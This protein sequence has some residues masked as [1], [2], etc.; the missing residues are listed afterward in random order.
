MEAKLIHAECMTEPQDSKKKA[1]L[2]TAR[3]VNIPC[4]FMILFLDRRD[5]VT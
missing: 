5:T 2:E 4:K 3:V 1:K